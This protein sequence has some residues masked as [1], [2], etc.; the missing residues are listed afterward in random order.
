MVSI[1]EAAKAIAV[2]RQQLYNV[3]NGRSAVAPETAVRFEEAFGG[4]ADPWLRMQAAREL[5]KVRQSQKKSPCADSRGRFDLGHFRPAAVEGIADRT[6]IVARALIAA[7][8][9]F[10]DANK[11]RQV[12]GTAT[13]PLSCANR[14]RTFE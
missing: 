4:G 9:G 2:T 3:I 10:I 13:R 7:R 6:G 11:G 8:H 12:T 14:H 1:A 5:A